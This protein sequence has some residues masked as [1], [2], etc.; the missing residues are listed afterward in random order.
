MSAY[1]QMS[2]T[3]SII[4]EDHCTEI[5]ISDDF[6]LHGHDEAS[7]FSMTAGRSLQCGLEG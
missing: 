3:L 5:L 1:L 2:V 4:S 6:S 7:P